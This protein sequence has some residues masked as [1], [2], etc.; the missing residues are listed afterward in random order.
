EDPP[1]HPRRP[2]G[3]GRLP[4]RSLVRRSFVA[5]APRTGGGG[6]CRG[7]RAPRGAG[8]G[9]PGGSRLLL[10][11]PPLPGAPRPLPAPSRCLRP[12]GG[13]S[14]DPQP[15]SAPTGNQPRL[16]RPSRG[17]P[18]AGAVDEPAAEGGQQPGGGR[19]D[20]VLPP[21]DLRCSSPP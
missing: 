10:R 5:P 13:G 18:L 15:V 6:P 16:T 2:G 9:A 11:H 3:A 4:G 14:A 17:S 8:A 12:P 19:I 21:R 7:D 1:G 20:A